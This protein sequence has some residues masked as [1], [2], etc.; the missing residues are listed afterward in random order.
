MPLFLRHDIY[1]FFENPIYFACGELIV[2]FWILTAALNQVSN[3]YLT[4][5]KYTNNA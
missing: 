3:I 1:C 2:N 5:A 4:L